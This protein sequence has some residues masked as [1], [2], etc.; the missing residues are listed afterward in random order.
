MIAA[1]CASWC[2]ALYRTVLDLLVARY[3]KIKLK[4][5]QVASNECGNIPLCSDFS[6]SIPTTA[7]QTFHFVSDC[8][9]LDRACSSDVY[10][11][12]E[13]KRFYDSLCY[14]CELLVVILVQ[15]HNSTM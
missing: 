10:S 13:N 15:P 12:L 6:K 9:K 7:Y 3:L 5:E 4:K 1:L 11:I 14:S 2:S 8:I